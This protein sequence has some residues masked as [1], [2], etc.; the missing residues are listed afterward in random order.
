MLKFCYAHMICYK[1]MLIMC[2]NIL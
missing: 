1:N 2:P